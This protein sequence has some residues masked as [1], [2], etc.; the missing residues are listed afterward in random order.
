MISIPVIHTLIRPNTTC[1]ASFYLI[2]F[3]LMLSLAIPNSL[4]VTWGVP[5]DIPGGAAWAKFHPSTY[6]IV[7]GFL[8]HRLSG[9]SGPV[10]HP[11]LT[12][13]QQAMTGYL[14][15]AVACGLY[16]LLRFGPNGSGFFVDTLIVPGL[17]G[18]ALLAASTDQQRQVFRFLLA[19]LFFNALLGIG[20]ALIQSRLMPYLVGDMPVEEDFFRATALGGHPLY[21]AQN[22]A[23]ISLA[24]LIYAGRR[25]LL[26]IPVFLLALLAFGSRAALV[27]LIGLWLV[28]AMRSFFTRLFSRQL[29]ARF[30]LFILF[31]LILVVGIVGVAIWEGTLGTRIFAEFYWD[32]SAR[33][34]S[35]AFNALGLMN[36]E[37]FLFGGG[38]E[39]G[40][41]ALEY[42][43]TS[44]DMAG[45]ENFWIMLILHLGVIPLLFLASALL[46][47]I[48]RLVEEESL[49]LK[50]TALAFLIL[51]S[52]T[53][54]L[55]SK[56]S[57]LTLL[58]A[59]L[60]GARAEA[61][62]QESLHRP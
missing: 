25:Q 55:A 12:R 40:E 28:W 19:V 60:I 53:N 44:S 58:M 37:T 45:I 61:A 18:S 50:L 36:L 3:G 20:E 5:Y 56:T 43:K 23:E 11:W 6:A 17:L 32:E 26:L 8:I 13:A 1:S 24:A 10:P 33:A 51:A 57:S 27:V 41:F 52:S 38:P 21:N 31:S 2:L 62:S 59:I 49:P 46:K 35:V 30:L 22:T 9:R 16:A 42:L 15:S 48:Y 47:M 29:D 54:S 14:L 34:R 39:F 7:L 4:L